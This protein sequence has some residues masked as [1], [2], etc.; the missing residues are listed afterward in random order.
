MLKA[1]EGKTVKCSLEEIIMILE[2]LNKNIKSWSTVHVFFKA[3]KTLISVNWEGENKIWFIVGDYPEMLN[4]A[5]IKVLKL[6]MNHIFEEK[7]EFAT[8]SNDIKK[9][10]PSDTVNETGDNGGKVELEV[11]EEIDYGNKVGNIKGVITGETEKALLLTLKL[12][13]IFSR[14]VR[15]YRI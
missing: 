15:V 4:F 1:G 5:Q 2:V 13:I 14:Q 11:L 7:I 6:L 10:V 12:S 8:V 3:D 9:D